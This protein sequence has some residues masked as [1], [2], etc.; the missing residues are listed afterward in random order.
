[1][2]KT[3]LWKNSSHEELE[4]SWDCI[5]KYI[6]VKIYNWY[7]S[8]FLLMLTICSCFAPAPEDLAKDRELNARIQQLSWLTPDH[9]DI[10]AYHR[11][12]RRFNIAVAGMVVSG[13]VLIIRSEL[14][15]MDSYK[16]PKDKM[17]CLLNSCKALYYILNKVSLPNWHAADEF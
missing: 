11:N 14:R 3:D 5:E 1:M 6:M 12:S 13:P 10:R 4:A 9:L 17:I 8:T 2:K 16:A 15:K 7:L